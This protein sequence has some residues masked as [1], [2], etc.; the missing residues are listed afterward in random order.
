MSRLSALWMVP[1]VAIGI[2]AAVWFVR[3]APEPARV[4]TA[5]PGLAVRIER[6]EPRAIR[7]LARGW[8]NVRAAESWTALAEVRGQVLWRHPDLEAGELIP[9]GTRVMEIDPAE[10]TAREGVSKES[11][12]QLAFRYGH[13]ARGV[14]RLAEID[15][16]M[17]KPIV[18]GMPDLMAEVQIA[19]EHEQARSLTDVL[20]RRTRLGI[21]AAS[22]LATAEALE[23]VASVMA[24]GLGWGEIEKKHQID[25]WLET[26]R[27][28]GLNPGGA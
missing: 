13:A 17:A 15:P 26:A 12:E 22:S 28:E 21:T 19:I 6:V 7:P 20:L 8:G 4:E 24:Q 5:L 23:P 1:P 16:E 10:L 2:A 25:N 11:L 9:A 18:E 14:V 27:A 3:N